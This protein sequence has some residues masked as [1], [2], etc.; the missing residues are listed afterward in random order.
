MQKCLKLFI[1]NLILLQAMDTNAL[2]VNF[3]MYAMDL[4]KTP[5][6][7]HKCEHENILKEKE[8]KNPVDPPYLTLDLSP[9]TAK[10]PDT[11][12]F[13][14]R[15]YSNLTNLDQEKVRNDLADIVS[16]MNCAPDS[17]LTIRFSSTRNNDAHIEYPGIAH[18]D[19]VNKIKF[20]GCMDEMPELCTFPSS[21]TRW[22][23]DSL[24]VDYEK[25][26]IAFKRCRDAVNKKVEEEGLLEKWQAANDPNSKGKASE[27]HRKTASSKN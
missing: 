9:E 7:S 21:I 24:I 25:M 12:G 18:K 13:C 16:E 20:Y 27:K 11:Y 6:Q 23:S 5:M 17:N 19:I 15:I 10:K 22:D 4:S 1:L 26:M 2:K 8:A 14:K 3:K